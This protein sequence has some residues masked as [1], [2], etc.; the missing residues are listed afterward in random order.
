[1][2]RKV[3]FLM[4]VLSLSCGL[5]ISAGTKVK[6]DSSTFGAIRARAIGPAVMGGRIAALD[7]VSRIPQIIYVGSAGGGVW[8]STDSGHSFKPVFDKHT[9]AIG[10]VAIDRSKTD[11]VWVGTGETWVRNSVSVGTGLYK[12]TDGGVNWKLVGLEKSER[13][14]RICIHPKNSDIVYVAALGHLW[15]ANEERGVYKTVDGGKTWKKVLYI[16]ENTGCADLSMDPQEPGVLYAAMWQFRRKPDFFNSGGPGSGLYKTVDG[17]KNW[18]KI[19]RGLPKE[20]LGRIAVAVAPSRPGRVYAVVESRKSAFYR[21]DDQGEHWTRVDSSTTIGER[22]FY[23][24]LVVVDPEDYKRVYKPG[25]IMSVSANAGKN[26]EQRYG[27]AH[28]DYHALWVNPDDPFNLVLGTDGGIYVSYDR[29]NNWRFLNSLPVSQ[30]YHVSYDMEKPYNVYGGLQDNGS[31]CG[32]SRSPGGIANSDWIEVGGGDGFYVLVDPHDSDIL[33]REYQGG[34]ISRAHRSTGES[35]DIRPYPKAGE[36]KYRFNWN[37]PIVVTANALYVGSQFLFRSTDK[38]ESWERISGDLTTN[39]PQKQRQLE[40]GGITVDNSTAENHC[41]IYTISESPVD[42]NVIWAGTDD[43][44]VQVTRNGGK[45]WTNVVKNIPDLPA[46][47]WCSFIET[48]RFALGTAYAAFDGHRTGDM[49]VY[50]Y[51]TADFGKT[52][53]SISSKAVKGYAFVIREDIKNAGLLFL[54]TEFGLFVTVDGGQQ[55]A[56][57]TGN[58]PN[59]AVRDIAIHP[60]DNDVILATHGRGIYI[61][62]DMALFRKITSDMLGKK[63]HFFEP[64]PVIIKRVGGERRS[65]NPGDFVGSNPSVV[66]KLTYFL[67][68]RHIFGDLKLEIYDSKGKL[69]KTLSGGKRRGINIVDW[70]LRLKAPKVPASPTRSIMIPSGPLVREG[71]YIAKLTKGKEIYEQKIKVMYDPD[72]RHSKEDRAWQQETVWKLYHMQEQLAYLAH[73]CAEARD[74]AR[75]NAEKLK[76]G[77]RLGKTLNRFA[78]KFD[79]LH[80]TLVAT[81]KGAGITG[82]EQLREEVVSLYANVNG[83]DGKP[84]TSQLNRMKVLEKEIDKANI[85]F[86]TIIDKELVG[87]NKKLENKKLK[88]L[89]LETKEEYSKRQDR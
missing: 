8:K 2:L 48:S 47:T 6:I 52:W 67:Q 80:K 78:D 40:T 43:G 3:L 21:S 38:G 4:L 73:S 79:Q 45:S 27:G 85:K 74:Q 13:I 49:N 11:T 84:T 58:L 37:T 70:P 14:A 15:D 55:W 20:N 31:W 87:I 29:G 66:G 61:I 86:K 41:T 65:A 57:F 64:E 46:C 17:G 51:K 23:F 83:Y 22:P 25:F 7:A 28:V 72:S 42:K 12:T 62:D 50:V 76:K 89:K 77:D 5:L 71:T 34:R 10:A 75:E 68:K 39:D 26:F 1:M 33:Y 30:F 88:P 54:G 36:P 82:E 9:Q 44:N 60:R 16:D 19:H 59:V 18:K 24:S 56:Q 53:H 69:I 35:K 63:V 81:R 32:P